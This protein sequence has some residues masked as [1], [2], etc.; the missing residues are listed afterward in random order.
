MKRVLLLF[1]FLAVLAPAVA[2]QTI[3]SCDQ[4]NYDSASNYLSGTTWHCAVTSTQ[5]AVSDIG[6]RY[7]AAD[8]EALTGKTLADT[9]A[10]VR[11]EGGPTINEVSYDFQLKQGETGTVLPRDIY[12]F[13]GVK[14]KL[15]GFNDPPTESEKN[16]WA[17]QNCY[18]FDYDG[19]IEYGEKPDL[20]TAAVTLTCL[21]LNKQY[22]T[23]ANIVDPEIQVAAE[24]TVNVDGQS[25]TKQVSNT[26]DYGDPDDS[27]RTATFGDIAFAR[28]R[29]GLQTGET[30]NEP[31][32]YKVLAAHDNDFTNNWR[33]ISEGRY[34][35]YRGYI[36]NQLEDD[37]AAWG[38]GELSRD[39][40]EQRTTSPA[41]SAI[42]P[43]NKFGSP[44]ANSAVNIDR[45]SLSSGGF[46]KTLGDLILLPI[47]DFY[48][49]GSGGLQIEPQIGRPNIQSMDAPQFAE[50]ETGTVN[51]EV[52]NSGTTEAGFTVGLN[53]A[54]GFR[55]GG[56]AKS[57]R[58]AENEIDTLRFSITGSSASSDSREFSGQCTAVMEEG[59]SGRTDS[60]TVTVNAIQQG[61][62]IAGDRIAVQENRQTV[63]KEC[64][65]NGLKYNVVETCADDEHAAT[66]TGTLQCVTNSDTDRGTNDGDRDDDTDAK[67]CLVDTT[68]HNPVANDSELEVLCV[69]NTIFDRLRQVVILVTGIAGGFVGFALGRFIDGER[70]IRGPNRYMKRRQV[71]RT[72]R[73]NRLSPATIIG[74]VL[75]FV[76]GATI[77]WYLGLWGYLVAAGLLFLKWLAPV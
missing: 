19:Q 60:M 7:D 70:R 31:A 59:N 73:G 22:A 2:G 21:D 40:L 68:L 39:D 53:C 54:D 67:T 33:M 10:F 4:L 46:S 32:N 6:I 17:R 20:W 35:D 71:D 65:S 72:Q 75:G 63:I 27:S 37:L 50:G 52:E 49:D 5:A 12:D 44:F 16:H 29:A 55:Y 26:Y 76:V 57:V 42:D 9:S 66:E 30:V 77:G 69:Q 3:N 45:Q 61:E 38:R 1:A 18:D 41:E 8:F 56:T 14:E 13:R 28:L 64:G 48:F 62:C 23:A 25:Y 74:A 43:Y 36:K 51:V 11:L 58:L 15:G 47:T 24:F 34:E